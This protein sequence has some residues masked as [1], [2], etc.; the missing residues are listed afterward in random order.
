[1]H[2]THTSEDPGL[3]ERAYTFNGP[4]R[5]YLAPR[6]AHDVFKCFDIRVGERER[7]FYAGNFTQD[8]VVVAKCKLGNRREVRRAVVA[9]IEISGLSSAPE[10][11]LR[12]LGALP[13]GDRTLGHCIFPNMPETD[14]ANA[15][16]AFL[17]VI[18]DMAKASDNSAA[19]AQRLLSGKETL[20]LLQLEA[21]PCKLLRAST[22]ARTSP[23]RSGNMSAV[24]GPPTSTRR[25]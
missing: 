13:L 9:W 16:A 23:R 2:W 10:E 6:T 22:G 14:G 1:M 24:Q 17:N 8:T 20:V 7:K 25:N 19:F 4:H 21:S 11:V 18:H 15:G 3:V 5:D 12:A